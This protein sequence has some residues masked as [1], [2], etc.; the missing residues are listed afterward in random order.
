MRSRV[1]FPTHLFS[2]RPLQ[3]KL[4]D[5]SA[6]QGELFIHNFILFAFK[7]LFTS[8]TLRVARF[9][10][11]KLEKE[12]DREHKNAPET[13]SKAGDSG[14]DDARANL[15]LTLKPLSSREG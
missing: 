10:P 12:Q 7:K 4:S 9:C 6:K 3:L 11:Q 5:I 8:F 14:S 2:D 15:A 1:C 13:F